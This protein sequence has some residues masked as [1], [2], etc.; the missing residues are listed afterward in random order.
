MPAGTFF[1]LITEQSRI[2]PDGIAIQTLDRQPLSYA[3]LYEHLQAI[4]ATLNSFEIGRN[5]RVAI[6][7]PNGPE[8]ATACMAVAACATCAPLNPEYKTSEFQ[9]F[10]SDLDAKLLFVHSEDIK[11]P[12]REVAQAMGIPI[13]EVT[14]SNNSAAG[15]FK[16]K[17][18]MNPSKT[19]HVELAQP[20][21]IAL[22]LHTSGTTSQPKIVPLS[23]R[24]IC[25]TVANVSHSLALGPQ[26]ICL[27]IMPLFHIGGL[28]DLLITPLAAGGS[29]ICTPN[30][31]VTTFIRHLNQFRPTWCQL[32][33]TMIQEIL[34]STEGSSL[35]LI[36]KSSLQ[37]IRSVAAALP[38]QLLKDF[39]HTFNIPVIE[40]Y[41]MTETTA[42]ITTN[43]LPPNK[44]KSGSVGI[45]AGP[46]VKI[47]DESG[48]FLQANQSGEVVV[49]GKNVMQGYENLPE[50]N[51]ETF[52]NSWFHTGDLGY[53]DEDD[54]LF[55]T[56]RLKEI[57]NRGGEKISP[58]EVDDVLFTHPAIAEAATFPVP[59]NSLGEE[60]AVAVILKKGVTLTEEELISYLGSNLAYFKVPRIVFFLDNLPKTPSGKLQRKALTETLNL[61]PS[62]ST[63]IRPSLVTPE[64]PLA[65]M[66]ANMWSK[67]LKVDPIGIH[68]NFFDLGGDSLKAATF[69]NELQEKW[70]GTIYVSA[71]F[72]APSIAEFEEFLNQNNS[73]GDH[74][75]KLEPVSRDAEPQLSYAQKRLLALAELQPNTSVY[76]ISTAFRLKGSLSI[77]NLEK[78][79]SE[80]LRRHEILRTTFPS[81][82]SQ[83]RQ[84]I[85]AATDVTIPVT[86]ICE[87]QPD[88]RENKAIEQLTKELQQ[89]FNLEQGP[90]WR[91]NLVKLATEDH[92]FAFTTHHLVFDGWSKD[93]LLRELSLLY[94][95]LANGEIPEIPPLPIQY[96]DFSHW[97]N[98]WLHSEIAEK[99]LSYWR[100]QLSGSI[101]ELM[102]PSSRSRPMTQISPSAN[103]SF[104]IPGTLTKELHEL[105][106][107][108]GVSIF[109]TLLTAFNILLHRYTGQDDLVLCLPVACRN[110]SEIE[111]LIGYFNNINVMRSDLSGNPSLRELIARIRKITL[112]AYENSEV[113]FQKIAEFSNLIRTPLTRGMF[114]FQNTPDQL[115]EL[116]GIKA[117]PVDIRK[118]TADFDLA[119][120]MEQKEEKL[121][122]VLEYNAD[123]F[124][125]SII[126]QLLNNFQTVLERMV[127]NANLLLSDLPHFGLELNKVESLLSNHPQVEEAVIIA[128]K[129][130]P[131]IQKLVAYI[132]LNQYDIPN[133]EG[134]RSFLK[135]RLPD[136]LVPFAFIPLDGLPLTDDGKIDRGVLPLTS[137]SR[138]AAQTSYV[139]PR[140]PLEEKLVKAWTKVLWLD[141]E[142]GI[143]DNFFDLGGHS[144]LSVQLVIEIEKI[145]HKKL[146]V[147]ALL[148]FGTIEELIEILEQEEKTQE[149]TPDEQILKKDQYTST[150]LE[151]SKLQPE[152]YHGLLAHTSGW[153]GKRVVPQSLIIGLNTE[154]TKQA[155]FWCCQG[156]RELTQLAKYFGPEQP[157]YGMRSGHRIMEKTQE[158][159]NAVSTYYV[160]EI[161]TIQPTGP[162]L[163]GGNCQATQIAFQ[164]ASQLMLQ[165][166]YITLLCLQEQ[167]VAQ[168]Y[169]GRVAFFYGE[170]SSCN[171]LHYFN[172]SEI[173]WKKFYTG[174]FSVNVISGKHGEFFRE[175]NIQVLTENLRAEIKQAQAEPEITM[176]NRAPVNYQAAP[177]S[178]YRA[179]I[180]VKKMFCAA[181][182]EK[183]TFPVKAKN[184]GSF[185]WIS[186]NKN[187]MITLGSRWANKDGQN[188]L[189][190]DS[191]IPLPKDMEPGSTIELQLTV[192][193]PAKPGRFI[194]EIDMVENGRDWFKD[195][196]SKATQLHIKIQKGAKFWNFIW[197]IKNFLVR[198]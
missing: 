108:E 19:K 110:R 106:R 149:E 164:I 83:P 67:A 141:Q 58:S 56:G 57:I 84:A 192:T 74:Y 143:R 107:R 188:I 85:S 147:N 100:N 15:L 13:I 6:V 109:I 88:H 9:F 92:F 61:A 71:I 171:P 160:G 123:L 126:T 157:I 35:E 195:K 47:I 133:I 113:P 130:Q 97:H 33:P 32:V 140:T 135:Q 134:L 29:V 118:Q 22:V 59:H 3:H 186:S 75:T 42:L 14:S 145:I 193:A 65:I 46:E 137:V 54:Y 190:I 63:T 10:L 127:S 169:P 138:N 102:L 23:Q 191:E 117:A 144:L 125:P 142:V 40:V 12:A 101:S 174:K 60:V 79:L 81:K 129:D 64:S 8:M 68:D 16:L 99:Q 176:P 159:I 90:L 196:G 24:N 148:K 86:D 94:N 37:Y 55:L 165:Q 72:D 154:G 49:R 51:A 185:T 27:N 76:N 104:N 131:G 25:A 21:D 89:P 124:N 70:G 45:A 48:S 17:A 69:I 112:A 103:Q 44:R 181:P 161:L 1:H 4:I 197:H 30:F 146:P 91:V 34:S 180:T 167:F 156:F 120:D 153:K 5:D 187:A 198:S 53:I 179:I 158:N 115:L 77:D 116:S 39:E 139:A 78:S 151:Q 189:S 132:V 122:G 36:K 162:F 66:L 7:L 87:L 18:K 96:A 38:T 173:G 166:H 182:C 28:V 175:P 93:I 111:N 11:T 41:G 172:Q 150:L 152:I 43:P 98:E 50:T 136:Y 194:L 177:D 155:L 168:H 95:A 82:N 2:H 114:S 121:S 31:S 184:T 183:I 26:D 170:D 105:S 73:D 128:Q 62:A 178:A 163:I 20:D 119:L 52:T 80:I